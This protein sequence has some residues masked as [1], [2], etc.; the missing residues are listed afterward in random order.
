MAKTQ[1]DIANYLD[2]IY[3]A[4]ILNG[5]THDEALENVSIICKELTN[6]MINSP[7]EIALRASSSKYSGYISQVIESSKFIEHSMSSTS[8]EISAYK[9]ALLKILER[10][11]KKAEKDIIPTNSSAKEIITNF[12]NAILDSD[13]EKFIIEPAIGTASLLLNINYNKILGFDINERLVTFARNL[14]ELSDKDN[15]NIYFNNSL[16]KALTI[17]DLTNISVNFKPKTDFSKQEVNIIDK[18]NIWNNKGLFIFDPPIGNKMQKSSLLKS[19]TTDILKNST[20]NYVLSEVNFLLNF[21][22]FAQNDS[23]CL[24]KMPSSF[25]TSRQRDLEVLREYIITNNLL[26]VIKDTDNFIIL[27]LQK[28]KRSIENPPPLPP[29][30]AIN[31]DSGLSE[32]F[33]RNIITQQDIDITSNQNINKL[34]RSEILDEI[35]GN[36]I[37]MPSSKIDVKKYEKPVYYFNK[38][39]GFE[40]EI[41]SNIKTIKTSLVENE[42]IYLTEEE[43]SQYTS[44]ISDKDELEQITPIVVSTNTQTASSNGAEENTEEAQPES[45]VSEPLN[46]VLWYKLLTQDED[47]ELFKIFNS[48]ILNIDDYIISITSS[49]SVKTAFG[50][51]SLLYSRKLIKIEGYK[52]TLTKSKDDLFNEENSKFENKILPEN[53]KDDNKR[54]DLALKI[55]SPKQK[56]LYSNLCKYW[57]NYQENS[58]KNLFD[59]YPYAYITRTLKLFETL[60]LVI[61]V[62]HE[63]N[64]TNYYDMFRPYHPLIDDF[65]AE[66]I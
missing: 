54:I 42:F 37:Q 39:I 20:E 24:C 34:T 59:S 48:E 31:F 25:L 49:N 38:I 3:D 19:K 53:Y 58:N 10:W 21:L 63:Q 16:N 1:N 28:K 17:K 23:Y 14:L 66:V 2:D 5:K 22:V 46:D 56:N 36:I 65:E 45:S 4:V 40:K 41:C 11:Q 13:T 50:Y 64:Y 62:D 52:I 7:Y 44:S 35:A 55:I 60:G 6:I 29:I 61:C 57:F 47:K 32:E 12:A 33:I 18:D 8:L 43:N 27:F 15:D 30:Y 51:L 9:N 26:A